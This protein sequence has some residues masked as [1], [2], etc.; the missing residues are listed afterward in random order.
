MMEI[1]FRITALCLTAVVLALV[2]KRS[3]GELAMLVSLAA[4]VAVLV[5]IGNELKEVVTFLR[6]LEQRSGLPKELFYPLYK[7]LGIAL[8]VRAGSTLCRDVG[9]SAVSAAL[10]IAGAVCALMVALP[11]LKA[12]LEL[13]M[14]FVA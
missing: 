13:L 2:V 11:L 12:V 4:V 14:G 10:E 3:N 1:V 6:T 8:V 7:T 9:E 5:G